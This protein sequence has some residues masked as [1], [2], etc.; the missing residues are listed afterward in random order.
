MPLSHSVN[1]PPSEASVADAAFYECR[2]VALRVGVGTAHERTVLEDVNFGVAAGEFVSVLG[3]SGVGKTTLLRVLGGLHAPADGSVVLF[4]GH[5]VGAPPSDIVTVFQDYATSL[6]PWRT[7]ERNVTLGIESTLSR[8]ERREAAVEALKMVELA[9]RRMDY[10]R[11]LSGGMQQRLQIARALVMRPAGLLMDEPFGAL[12]AMTKAS[13]QDI[14]LDIQAKTDMTIVFVTHDIDEA[15]YLSDRILV[16]GGSPARVATELVID[17]PR[18]RDQIS[19]KELPGFLELR[20]AAYEAI[21]A[22]RA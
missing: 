22:K 16:L 5:P 13:L 6:L 11:Q 2:N 1:P 15:V 4:R 9:D 17:L 8:T 3:G 19:T 21:G 14:L 20:H 10:P 12:D 7:V 18:P